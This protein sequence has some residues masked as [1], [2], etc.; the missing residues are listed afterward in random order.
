MAPESP[1]SRDEIQTRFGSSAPAAAGAAG[2]T[3]P[4]GQ[5]MG[6]PRDFLLYLMYFPYADG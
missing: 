2:G 4:A 5:L 6:V 3:N 1:P